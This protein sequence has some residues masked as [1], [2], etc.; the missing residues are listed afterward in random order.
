MLGAAPAVAHAPAM[1]GEQVVA[2][3][4]PL[5]ANGLQAAI[6]TR[7]EPA[8]TATPRAVCGTGARP[9]PSIQG[10]VPAAFHNNPL[11]LSLKMYHYGGKTGVAQVD[12]SW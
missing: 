12:I 1:L 10:R 8:Q 3:G 6:A 9:E 2:Q 4:D 5:G 11:R 7:E